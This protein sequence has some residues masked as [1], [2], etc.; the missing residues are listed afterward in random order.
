MMRSTTHILTGCLTLCTLALTL[1]GCDADP[2]RSS[3]G[4]FPD[5][6]VEPW[7]RARLIV[8][9][10]EHARNAC[11]VPGNTH[12]T[13]IDADLCLDRLARRQQHC[14]GLAARDMPAFVL[15]FDDATRWGDSYARCMDG[16]TG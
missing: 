13:G 9:F 8:E 2:N 5:I 7:S 1:A 16:E 3:A 10:K 6:D 11:S 4:R 15:S 12:A 14:D